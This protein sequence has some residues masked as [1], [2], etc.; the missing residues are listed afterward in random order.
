MSMQRVEIPGLERAARGLDPRV[1]WALVLGIPAL[2]IGVS[3]LGLRDPIGLIADFLAVMLV[4]VGLPVII[5]VLVAARNCR[6]ETGPDGLL[7]RGL[8]GSKFLRWTQVNSVRTLGN[9][10]LDLATTGGSLTIKLGDPVLNASVMQ[11]LSRYLPQDALQFDHATE[12]IFAPAPDDVLADIVWENP[13][14]IRVWPRYLAV[15][16]SCVLWTAVIVDSILHR[17]QHFWCGGMVAPATTL[18][19]AL[20]TDSRTIARRVTA[21]ADKLIV[22]YWRG[23]AEA[24]WDQIYT[25]NWGRSHVCIWATRFSAYI[26]TAER[27]AEL[28][29]L[30]RAI[31]YR[32]R[33]R[34]RPLV[35][36]TDPRQ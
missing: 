12:S 30:L 3:T 27:T 35:F 34:T 32:L 22:E 2:I 9:G 21:T 19:L 31:S 6:R 7:V 36:P 8:Y 10:A 11:H 4:L 14:L 25:I 13:R 23:R 15:I 17:S 20:G 26:P 24:T 16:I 5:W 1:V 18:I 28:D 29:R 33:T